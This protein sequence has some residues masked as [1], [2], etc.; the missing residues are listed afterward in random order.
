MLC[1]WRG[2][3]CGIVLR[4]TSVVGPHM[5]TIG[6][7][8]DTC[9]TP[10]KHVPAPAWRI[11]CYQALFKELSGR[12]LQGLQSAATYCMVGC[13]RCMRGILQLQA[14]SESHAQAACKH[15][16]ESLPVDWMQVLVGVCI[17]PTHACRH[18][19]GILCTQASETAKDSSCRLPIT[20][21]CSRQ[22]GPLH[23]QLSAHK[24][25]TSCLWW[26]SAARMQSTGMYRSQHGGCTCS[27]VPGGLPRWPQ[28]WQQRCD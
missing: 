27:A 10:H 12:L 5:G 25:S 21:A 4:L 28:R 22:H 17:V 7:E 13:A 20:W 1:R 11:E 9:A 18:T 8:G 26:M 24:T 23:V 3:T 15:L 19:R 6:G 14:P 16:V 2:P